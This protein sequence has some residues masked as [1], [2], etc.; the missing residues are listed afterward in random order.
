MSKSE[1]NVVKSSVNKELGSNKTRR[2]LLL[3]G[4]GRS[5]LRRK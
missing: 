2:N 4:A 5:F 3:G 1:K